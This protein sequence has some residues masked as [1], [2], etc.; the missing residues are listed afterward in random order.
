MDR[1]LIDY[2]PDVLKEYQEII[3]IMQSE[4]PEVSSLWGCIT[5]VLNDQF[6][7]DA[8]TNGILRWEKILGI[9]PK[10]TDTLDLR[11][12]RILARLSEQRPYTFTSLRQQMATLCGEEGYRIEVDNETYTLIVKVELTAKGKYDEVNSL[13]LRIVPANMI[14]DLSLLYNQYLT[15]STFTYSNLSAYTYEQLRNEVIT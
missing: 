5:N 14:I 7:M 12:F 9:S 15:L 8:T 2:L 4:Q 6:V 1:N 3:A 11:K 13:L 10:G